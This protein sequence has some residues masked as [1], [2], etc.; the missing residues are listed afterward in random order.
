MSSFGRDTCVNSRL[1]GKEK[2]KKESHGKV[3]VQAQ[4]RL[5]QPTEAP[6]RAVV[7]CCNKVEPIILSVSHGLRAGWP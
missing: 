6:A 3:D 1:G 2:E 5:R 7:R 4:G